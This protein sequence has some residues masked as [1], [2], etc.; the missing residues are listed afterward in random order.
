MPDA[1]SRVRRL[2]PTSWRSY[3]PGAAQLRAQA[4][5]SW[6]KDATVGA[7]VA[8]VAVPA[9]MGMAELAG[10][11]PVYGLW[12][13]M[14][15]LVAYALFGSSR[16]L[17]VGPEGTLSALTATAVAPLAAGSGDRYLVLVAGLAMVMGAVLLAASALRLGFMADFLSKPVLLG[18]LNGVSLIII[19]TQLG[20]LL[21]LSVKSTEFLPTV[22]KVIQSLGSVHFPTLLL[23]VGLLASALLMQRFTPKVPGSLVVVVVAIL[24]S[25]AFDFEGRGIAVVGDLDGGLPKLGLPGVRLADLP[26]LVLPA[27]GMALV[28]FADGNAIARTFATK[29]GYEV[30]ANQELAALGAANLT[31]GLSGTMPIGSSGSRT[32]LSDSAGGRSQVVGL[33]AAVIVGVIA[34]VA[35][36]LIAPLPKAALGVVVVAAALKLIDVGGILRLRRIRDAEA[37]LAVCALIGVLALGVLNGLL[38]AV[39]LSIGVFVYRTV[40]PHDA[41]LGHLDDIDGYR[42]IE[43]NEGA[44]TLP[45]LVVYRFDAALYFPN[46]PFFTERLKTLVAG[47]ETPVRWVLVNAEAVTYIDS[48]A[49]DALRELRDDLDAQGVVLAFARCKASLRRVFEDTGFTAETGERHFYPTVRAGVAAYREAT[50]SR[51]RGG[52]GQ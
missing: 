13:T 30:S 28:A 40:R 24:A 42:D 3:L 45:G 46:V 32:A 16:Q 27:A 12:S 22:W 44:Q 10:V 26:D 51:R 17:V 14:L 23:S 52:F 4:P 43:E 50:P 48:T 8:A 1:M 34:A 35:T 36:P 33:V 21:G 49:V 2:V 18:Y 15:P 39:A 25:V 20:K 5:T 19:S 7:T 37:G 38:V 29:N 41:L 9:A 47:Q 11:P 31:S 6:K